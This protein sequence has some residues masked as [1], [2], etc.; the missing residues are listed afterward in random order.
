MPL[1][2]TRSRIR[3]EENIGA[4]SVDLSTE[5]LNAINEG[6]AQVRIVG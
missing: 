5:D 2:G 1:F 4:L 3:F 6:A